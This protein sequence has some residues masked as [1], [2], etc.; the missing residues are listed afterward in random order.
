MGEVLVAEQAIMGSDKR[1][2]EVTTHHLGTI[3]GVQF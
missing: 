1:T 3:L 2:I